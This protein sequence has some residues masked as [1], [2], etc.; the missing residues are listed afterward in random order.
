MRSPGGQRATWLPFEHDRNRLAD[1]YAAAELVAAPCPIETFGLAGLEALASGVPVL[2]ADRGG[3]A[4]MV[5]RSG[6]R[7][8]LPAGDRAGLAEAAVAMLQGD[9]RALGVRGRA[10]AEAHHGWDGVFDRLFEV[11][12]RGLRQ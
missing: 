5:E 3:V 10:Y 8:T 11:Y 12:R 7:V 2:A 6:G 4:E 9:L 1:L